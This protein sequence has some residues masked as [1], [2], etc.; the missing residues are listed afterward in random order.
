M[1]KMSRDNRRISRTNADMSEREREKEEKWAK[2]QE[3]INSLKVTTI[4]PKTGEEEVGTE[5]DP[6]KLPESMLRKEIHFKII[7]LLK[8]Y[9][10]RFNNG[11]KGVPN[12]EEQKE[13]IKITLKEI[14]GENEL[15]SKLEIYFDSWIEHQMNNF[16]KAEKDKLPNRPVYDKKKNIY[17]EKNDG[18]EQEI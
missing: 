14:F 10:K 8:E 16:E 15:F 1:G 5:F 11:E 3:F 12:K 17:I 7:Q 2:K 13:K 18:E 6:K 9:K 4:N